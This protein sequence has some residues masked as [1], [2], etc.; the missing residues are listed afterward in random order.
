LAD[1]LPE[2]VG[3]R[4]PGWASPCR[5]SLKKRP[6]GRPPRWP[7]LPGGAPRPA[8]LGDLRQV[9]RAR[10]AGTSMSIERLHPNLVERPSRG[11]RGP[12]LGS[13]FHPAVHPQ[14]P[15]P[16]G[17]MSLR[18]TTGFSP[19]QGS[20]LQRSRPGRGG[21]R[22][23]PRRTDTTSKRNPPAEG[24]PDRSGGPP[25][26]GL[27]TPGRGRS[28][29]ALVASTNLENGGR[30]NPQKATQ[31]SGMKRRQTTNGLRRT[32]GPA[33]PSGRGART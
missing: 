8:G 23:R 10:K 13:A 28:Q 24:G 2:G 4:G 31:L 17:L 5:P 21:L 9:R 32:G 22:A 11:R 15:N 7:A 3:R 19:G 12:G 26:H 27:G 25:Q 1:A 16:L 18:S 14:T 33:P 30:K 6:A 20:G 29:A